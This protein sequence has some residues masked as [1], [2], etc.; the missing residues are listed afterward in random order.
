[1]V[2][3]SPTSEEWRKLYESVVRVKEIS[4]WEW[5]TE[6]EIFGVQNPETDELG[7]VSVMGML[8]EH[9]AVSLYLGS[10]GLYEFWQFEEMGDMIDPEG[11]LEIPQLQASFENRE[12]L[13][14]RDREVI[15]E[16]GLK[17]RGRHAWPMF[18]SYRPGFF[19]WF[20]ETEEARFLTYALNQLADVAPRL[21]EESSLLET[22]GEES[23]LVRVPRRESGTLVW[24]DQLLDVPPP[25]PSPI[26]IELD[27]QVLE[28]LE[29][30]P[31]SE[32]NLEIDFFM[33]P[34]PIQE[35][36]KTRPI[37]PY[38]L[39]TVDA[40]S[41]MIL[42]NA[43]L[44]PDPSMEAMWGSIPANVAHQLARAGIMPEDV[45]V[46][47][48]LLFQLLQPLAESLGFKLEQSQTLPN[49]HP[50]KELLL[51]TVYE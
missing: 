48:E 15:K 39:L 8:G 40:Q 21:R 30:L 46:G 23:Y 9:Y 49:L 6:A 24:E 20:L 47:S 14:K 5:M 13:D 18:R 38:M 36:K 27:V 19:P 45:M 44:T 22:S 12:E 1:M 17:F 32:N 26:P 41:G 7:F 10:E 3:N 28:D 11:L 43:I 51:Q 35:E 34:A 50:V 16:L 25:E 37:F 29:Q 4:P 31:P 42:G 2:E 33:F